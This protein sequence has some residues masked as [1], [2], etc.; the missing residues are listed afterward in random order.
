MRRDW[1]SS[2]RRD[3]GARDHGLIAS[4]RS[5]CPKKSW[6]DGW[7]RQFTTRMRSAYSLDPTGGHP[8]G[9]M[10]AVL[11]GSGSRNKLVLLSHVSERLSVAR[12]EAAT[13]QAPRAGRAV[14]DDP[15]RPP[16]HAPG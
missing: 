16:D 15:V 5:P 13:V 14:S 12:C 2:G 9:R 1:V 7:Q 8:S 11:S 6:S 4:L 10:Q 3:H